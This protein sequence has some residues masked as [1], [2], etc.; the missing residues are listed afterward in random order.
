MQ[1]N[2][3]Q[4][5]SIFASTST[6]IYSRIEKILP[7]LEGCNPPLRKISV[8]FI[9]RMY[10][11]ALIPYRITRDEVEG[12]CLYSYE[13]KEANMNFF[14]SVITCLF[15]HVCVRKFYVTVLLFTIIALG[16]FFFSS[17]IF[18]RSWPLHPAA[19]FWWNINSLPGQITIIGGKNKQRELWNACKF[20]Y[21]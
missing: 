1:N 4:A 6:H 11:S 16:T 20:G 5:L 13:K 12:E 19:L 15:P 18:I 9:T 8:N 3:L 14:H 2:L 17:E 7:H 21:W 10:N